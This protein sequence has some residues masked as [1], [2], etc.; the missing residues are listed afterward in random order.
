MKFKDLLHDPDRY[1]QLEEVLIKI[2]KKYPIFQQ[3]EIWPEIQLMYLM[4]TWW[5]ET[6]DDEGEIVVDNGEIPDI[7]HDM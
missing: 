6:A 3:S 2:L 1:D 7:F 5:A 4:S